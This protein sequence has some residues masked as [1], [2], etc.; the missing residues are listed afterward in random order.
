MSSILQN[1]NRPSWND[2]ELKAGTKIRTALWLLSE[3]GVGN[4]FTKEQHRQAFPG[5]AQADRRLRD[6]RDAGWI[7]HTNLED[8]SLNANE[9]RFV[10]AGRPI[11]DPSSRA[12]GDLPVLTAKQRRTVFAESGYQCTVCGIAGGENYPDAQWMSA[13][14]SVAKQTVILA[15]GRSEFRYATECKR[16]QSGDRTRTDDI[17]TLLSE[18][19]ALPDRD[20][21]AVAHLI[22]QAP[23]SAALKAWAK[24]R[25]LS[26]AA[27]QEV[28]SS[29]SGT[30]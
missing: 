22:S 20:K 1:K 10:E 13:T 19:A 30:A 28:R 15:D 29:V 9:Q 3:V 11:W 23:G 12:A 14:L 8:V 21:A 6:L 4:I 24:Y 16:C 25:N 18:I 26:P 17:A 27:M 7:I 2:P 5:I